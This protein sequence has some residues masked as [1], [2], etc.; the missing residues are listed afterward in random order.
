MNVRL[1]FWLLR[2]FVLHPGLDYRHIYHL[3]SF[4]DNRCHDSVLI[5]KFVLK[6]ALRLW[7]WVSRE[8]KL[9]ILSRTSTSTLTLFTQDAITLS[10]CFLLDL[11]CLDNVNELLFHV[12]PLKIKHFRWQRRFSAVHHGLGSKTCWTTGFCTIS[13]KHFSQVWR[14][15]F[16]ERKK[17]FGPWRHCWVRCQH[18]LNRHVRRDLVNLSNCLERVLV[19]L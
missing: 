2:L 10:L 16:A 8:W 15:W 19:K 17:L 12:H 4:F 3:G 7:W 9:Q 1:N 13:A 14:S 11:R 5:P 18:A 6:I